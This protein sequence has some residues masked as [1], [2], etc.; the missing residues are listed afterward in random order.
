LL[1]DQQDGREPGSDHRR[2]KNGGGLDERAPPSPR[3][4]DRG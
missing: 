2:H 3:R 4:D 1:Y